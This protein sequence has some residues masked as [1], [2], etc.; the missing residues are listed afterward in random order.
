D[1]DIYTAYSRGCSAQRLRSI[2]ADR[3]PETPS[4]P[5]S[6]QPPLKDWLD[7][8]VKYRRGGSSGWNVSWPYFSK[9]TD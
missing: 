8:I 4:G 5:L 1:Y 6:G 7:V 9:L 3:L 2:V